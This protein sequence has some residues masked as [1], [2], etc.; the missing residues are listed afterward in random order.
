M[1]N[2]PCSLNQ[3]SNRNLLSIGGFKLV[4]NKC[5][6]VDFL[7]NKANLPG[8]SLGVAVQPSYLRDLPVPGDK[9]SYE[10]LR[11]DFLVDENLENYI[12]IYDWM[13]SLGFPESL[14]QFT[15]LQTESRYFPDKRDGF[16]E[17]SD[18]TL[19][20]LN[21][22]YQEAGKVKFRDL[23]PVEL[24]GLPFDATI[25]QQE[26]FTATCLFKYTMFD[27]IDNEGKEA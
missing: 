16:Q 11:I 27:L 24:T 15:E 17:R 23:F 2:N 6:K 4:I 18:A 5:P 12:Q 26:Y 7:C 9:I 13:T 21:S 8:I 10:D 22:N 25:D 19:I 3:V 1:S 20:I 14:N